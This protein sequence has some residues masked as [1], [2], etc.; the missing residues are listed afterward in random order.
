MVEGLSKA[1]YRRTLPIGDSERT[2]V[3]DRISL[4]CMWRYLQP[5]ERILRS[6]FSDTD[7]GASK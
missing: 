6:P 1:S 5:K 7:M 4:P 2:D 3:V